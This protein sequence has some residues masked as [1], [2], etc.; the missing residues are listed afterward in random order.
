[1][2]VAFAHAGC[3]SR[4]RTLWQESW[5]RVLS[6]LAKPP[7][8]HPAQPRQLTAAAAAA[9]AQKVAAQLCAAQAIQRTWRGYQGRRLARGVVAIIALQRA[10]RRYLA[11]M[12]RRMR[13]LRGC[14]FAVIVLVKG[15]LRRLFRLRHARAR[16]LQRAFRRFCAV[17]RRLRMH[18]AARCVG[19][20]WRAYARRCRGRRVRWAMAHQRR[21]AAARR[22]QRFFRLVVVVAHRGRMMAKATGFLAGVARRRVARCVTGRRHQRV[23]L[24]PHRHV[25]GLCLCC[26]KLCVSA[27]ACGC[28]VV[29]ACV[30]VA[31]CTSRQRDALVRVRYFL[32]AIRLQRSWRARYAR[33]NNAAAQMQRIWRGRAA[34]ELHREMV[35]ITRAA[36]ELQHFWKGIAVRREYVAAKAARE[37]AK[38][39]KPT[40]ANVTQVCLSV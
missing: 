4:A 26:V 2:N 36:M 3:T 22:L 24:P 29:C 9:C 27:C 25:C 31:V 30:L 33:L 11:R 38:F 20:A 5:H 7:A 16:V 15:F 18:E 28:V 13:R 1:M 40:T 8:V 12:R 37:H 34:R 23:W 10:R 32:V 6:R 35:R 19:G 14:S 39:C 17:Q 21:Y